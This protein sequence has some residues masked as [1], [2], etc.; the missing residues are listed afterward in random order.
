[1]KR[2]CLKTLLVVMLLA[3]ASVS[4]Q[5]VYVTDQLQIGL[6]AEKVT[7]SPIQKIVPTGTALQVVK[8]EEK[9]SFVSEPGGVSGWV[10]NTYLITDEPGSN[11]LPEAEAKILE[12]EETLAK[13]EMMLVGIDTGSM[14]AFETEIDALAQ[15]LKSE[16]IRTGELQAELAELRKRLGQDNSNDSLYQKID[17]LSTENRQL[18]IQLARILEDGAPDLP[19]LHASYLD[20][21]S[22]FT[23]T[24]MI[25]ALVIVLIGGVILGLY[26]MD[27]VI[28]RRHGGFR[29]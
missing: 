24:N 2:Y 17:S 19:E 16:R 8:A 18:Q 3:S 28:R 14:Q 25:I 12:L 5:T 29:I 15:Q 22:F 20:T 1:M 4:G 26:L 11:R 23:P 7:D 10:D 9:M 21:R 27:I 6:H 13:A